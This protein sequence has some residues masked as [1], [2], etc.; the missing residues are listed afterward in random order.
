M[1][2]CAR[3]VGEDG[4]IPLTSRLAIGHRQGPDLSTIWV[5]RIFDIGGEVNFHAR[6]ERF[7]D[8]LLLRLRVLTGKSSAHQDALH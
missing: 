5:S 7:Q 4:S 1:I 6:N 8:D 3:G 2:L